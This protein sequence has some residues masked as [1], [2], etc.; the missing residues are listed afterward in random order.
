MHNNKIKKL[1]ERFSKKR[2]PEQLADYNET[3]T[4]IDFI[5]PFFSALG[6]DVDNKAGLTE[7]YRTV[8]H[9]ETV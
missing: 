1:Q 5:N 6:W 9:E 3:Q 4:R 7:S 2:E 8:V